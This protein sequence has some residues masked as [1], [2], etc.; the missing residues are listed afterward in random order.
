MA[1][2]DETADLLRKALIKANKDIRTALKK[3]RAADPT[4]CTLKHGTANPIDVAAGLAVKDA[5]DRNATAL[6]LNPS[7]SATF[8]RVWEDRT[9]VV[10]G[11][12]LTEP[13]RTYILS[14]EYGGKGI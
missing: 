1:S 2:N 7:R 6:G 11:T 12:T 9:E 14:V 8:K 3:T 4:H 5:F 13:G 10:D